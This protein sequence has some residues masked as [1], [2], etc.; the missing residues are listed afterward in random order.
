MKVLV[1]E[2]LNVWMLELWAHF[3][4]WFFECSKCSNFESLNVWKL[5]GLKVWTLRCLVI[6]HVNML[7]FWLYGQLLTFQCLSYILK[8]LP[9]TRHG[10]KIQTVKPLKVQTFKLSKFDRLKLSNFDT[11]QNSNFQ[12]FNVWKLQTFNPSVFESFKHSKNQTLNI[13][14]FSSNPYPAPP[15]SFD[16][17]YFIL[18]RSSSC[19]VSTYILSHF[20]QIF[21]HWFANIWLIVHPRQLMKGS[22]LEFTGHCQLGSQP[23]DPFVAPII[24]V[25]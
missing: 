17:V 7:V 13:V 24:P 10:F 9:I 16:V 18:R 22:L 5:Q 23:W 25:L 19:I 20:L 14:N 15:M 12:T 11:F 4:V 3:N 1:F 8:H 6:W 2:S 21:E